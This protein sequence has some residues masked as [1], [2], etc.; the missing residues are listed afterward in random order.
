M[1][2]TTPN[3]RSKLNKTVKV[4][5]GDFKNQSGI[6]LAASSK[7]AKPVYTLE[8]F[9]PPYYVIEVLESEIEFSA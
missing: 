9:T 5:D 2:N 1:K 8:L 4:I 3:L 6:V 7:Y